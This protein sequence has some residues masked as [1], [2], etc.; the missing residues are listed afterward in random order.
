MAHS[1]SVSEL[2]VLFEQS[3]V[4]NPFVLLLKAASAYECVFAKTYRCRRARS[5]WTRA[6]FRGSKRCAYWKALLLI[7]APEK[8]QLVKLI[9]LLLNALERRP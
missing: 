3:K 1:L 4:L 5:S 9:T 2:I 7:T 8:L 6:F